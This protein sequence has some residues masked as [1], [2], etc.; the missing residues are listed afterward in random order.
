MNIVGIE[1][2][3]FLVKIM[4]KY[5]FC[6]INWILWEPQNEGGTPTNIKSEMYDWDNVDFFC[7]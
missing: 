3:A 4:K 6:L 2:K 1:N 7:V 5:S